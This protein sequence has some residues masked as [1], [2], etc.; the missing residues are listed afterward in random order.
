MS[1]KLCFT[2]SIIFSSVFL[3]LLFSWIKDSGLLLFLFVHE[4]KIR[5]INASIVFFYFGCWM[6]DRI[7]DIKG[8]GEEKIKYFCRKI[9]IY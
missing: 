4:S 3:I 2:E 8:L 5:I 7:F 9:A 6:A 1:K